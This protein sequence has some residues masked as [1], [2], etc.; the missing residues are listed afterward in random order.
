MADEI[1]S[2]QLLR[3]VDANLNRICEGLRVLEEAARFVL[4]DPALSENLKELRHQ[5]SVREMDAKMRYLSARDSQ[6]DVGADITTSFQSGNQS[7][8]ETVIAN[9]RRVEEALRVM[10]EMSKVQGN[11]MDAQTY[12][13]ARFKLYTIEKE[14]VG[15]L[16][17]KDV[18]ARVYGLYA[19]VDSDCLRGRNIIEITEQVLA[20]GVKLVQLR[21]K[22]SGKKELLELSLAL[23]KLCSDNDAL[24]IINDHLDIALASNA[25]GLHVGQAD[26]PVKEARSLMPIDKL[27]GCSVTS[28]EEARK[29]RD[30]GADYLGCGAIYA[31]S[32]KPDCL[33]VGLDALREIKKAVDLPLVAIGG[34]NIDNLPDIFA[35]GA[36]AAAVISAVALA[37]SPEAAAREMLER[38][39]ACHEQTD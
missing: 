31:T 33:V 23:K 6:N 8:I 12:Q 20:G 19:V 18:S 34:I 39:E 36:D 2:K 28:I 16:M 15:R 22:N 3:I 35:A 24:L 29:A 14:L 10:E 17:R 26:L 9:A 4:N 5:L 11:G 38:I 1:A 21:D 7:L 25:D 13:D 32:T 27:I 30:D 37:R